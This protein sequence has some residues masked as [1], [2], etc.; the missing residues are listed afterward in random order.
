MV[1]RSGSLS[2]AVFLTLLPALA[3]AQETTTPVSPESGGSSGQGDAIASLTTMGIG[4]LV[5]VALIFGCAWLVKRMSGL[6]GMNSGTMKVV[7]V[8]GLG[9]RERIALID[10]AGTQILVGITPSAIRTLHVFDEPV[11]S[12]GQEASGDF[13]RKLHGLI[14][15]KWKPDSADHRQGGPD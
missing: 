1:W 11:V 13:A 3:I 6:T 14:G 4:L 2:A 10:V 8:M 7:A 5:V 15:R 12:P 9:A